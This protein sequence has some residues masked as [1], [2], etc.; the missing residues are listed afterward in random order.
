MA[1]SGS[2]NAD[3]WSDDEVDIGSCNWLPAHL[4]DVSAAGTPMLENNFNCVHNSKLNHGKEYQNIW[5]QHNAW[6]PPFRRQNGTAK[7]QWQN[8]KEWW[9][10]GIT[11]TYHHRPHASASNILPLT[12]KVNAKTQ[13]LTPPLV[14]LKPLKYWNQNWTNHVHWS[15]QLHQFLNKNN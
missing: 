8:G 15:L 3:R 2:M 13:F 5:Q 14:D 9:K 1:K 4:D 12:G 10:P 7:R 6:F 11:L